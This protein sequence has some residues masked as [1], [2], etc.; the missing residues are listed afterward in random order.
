[1]RDE[2]S[3]MSLKVMQ[4]AVKL[5]SKQWFWFYLQPV[6]ISTEFV[7]KPKL[8]KTICVMPAHFY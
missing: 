6:V 3:V 4:M 1:M 5:E 2:K 7:E 8:P